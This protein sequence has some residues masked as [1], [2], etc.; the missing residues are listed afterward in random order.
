MEVPLALKLRVSLS[1]KDHM[2]VDVMGGRA[3]ARWHCRVIIAAAW[4]LY[5]A[6]AVPRAGAQVCVG[7]C[8]GKGSVGISDLILGVN[9]A[10]GTA[11]LTQCPEFDGNK[12][13][14]V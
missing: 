2:R 10:L 7:D 5:G 13:G 3:P 11:S 1:P 9:I 4:V 14:K 8:G 12:D 6:I